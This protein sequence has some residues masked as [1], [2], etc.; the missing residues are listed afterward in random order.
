MGK[1]HLG[2]ASDIC[3]GL[4]CRLWHPVARA[5]A[6]VE[7]KYDKWREEALPSP[8]QDEVGWS[9]VSERCSFAP[10]MLVE[11]GLTLCVGTSAFSVSPS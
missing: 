7:E 8:A 10:L 11:R 1:I 9:R 4:L 2:A 5:N 6:V 3:I